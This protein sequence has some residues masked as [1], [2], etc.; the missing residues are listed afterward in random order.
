MQFFQEKRHPWKKI[1]RVEKKLELFML[2]E[3]FFK[4]CRRE[5]ADVAPCMQ[6]IA[7]NNC[8]VYLPL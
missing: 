6:E 3:I 4:R 7:C 8:I 5:M 2:H 1:A